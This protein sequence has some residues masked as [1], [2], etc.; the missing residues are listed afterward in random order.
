MNMTKD[1]KN[2]KKSIAVSE[3]MLK[4]NMFDTFLE[5][6]KW[7]K[8]NSDIRKWIPNIDDTFTEKI[9][10]YVCNVY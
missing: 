3:V 6:I 7:I 5:L 1:I 8:V 4:I 9:S 10:I 2:R